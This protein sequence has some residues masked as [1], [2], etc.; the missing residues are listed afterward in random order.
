M[1]LCSGDSPKRNTKMC[2]NTDEA[3]GIP[4]LLPPVLPPIESWYIVARKIRTGTCSI[5]SSWKNYQEETE[6]LATPSTSSPSNKT[7]NKKRAI[8]DAKA[9]E[10]AAFPT[11]AQAIAY[12][13][14]N[15]PESPRG[16]S[17]PVTASYTSSP[18]TNSTPG[19]NNQSNL[20]PDDSQ[21]SVRSRKRIHKSA[22]KAIR[23]IDHNDSE[24]DRDSHIPSDS[25]LKKRKVDIGSIRSNIPL[26]MSRTS[27]TINIGAQTRKKP[28]TSSLDALAIVASASTNKKA[29]KSIVSNSNA[30][31]TESTRLS[32]LHASIPKGFAEFSES[33]MG[34]PLPDRHM[35]F[36]IT[37]RNILNKKQ[38]QKSTT[39]NQTQHQ[40]VMLQLQQEDEELKHQ[41]Q[42]EELK[43]QRI[44]ARKESLPIPMVPTPLSSLVIPEVPKG[45]IP[46][47]QR[48]PD[49][50]SQ[51]ISRTIYDLKSSIDR[52]ILMNG[53]VPSMG[54][55]PSSSSSAR[56]ISNHLSSL[57]SRFSSQLQQQQQQHL[58]NLQHQAS[59]YRNKSNMLSLQLQSSRNPLIQQLRGGSAGLHLQHNMSLQQQLQQSQLIDLASSSSSECDHSETTLKHRNDGLSSPMIL[60]ASSSAAK[61]SDSLHRKRR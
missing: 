59:V 18:A 60:G 27:E 17:S 53:S 15:T 8:E 1:E 49:R 26:A 33:G 50:V 52:K 39:S 46:M 23:I 57:D 40:K 47:E 9:T 12:V 13:K 43:I 2:R 48:N 30:A 25:P 42:Q 38:P 4:V 35:P 29:G 21:S 14:N 34:R 3:V 51:T 19:M 58:Q 31:A 22:M 61:K 6:L 36:I 56:E 37:A 11:V 45:F 32:A 54:L 55:S 44:K 5:Y 16:S 41:I 24:E 7:E 28:E 20:S 10:M